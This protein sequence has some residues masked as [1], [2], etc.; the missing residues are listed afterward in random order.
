M[1][2]RN[3]P[4]P[5]VP[6]PGPSDGRQKFFE[7]LRKGLIGLGAL[8]F[9]GFLF[10]F[11]NWFFEYQ[12]GEAE[13]KAFSKANFFLVF[14]L[15]LAMAATFGLLVFFDVTTPGPLE[16]KIWALDLKGPAGP[17]I[18]WV[19]VSLSVVLAI[20]TL[21]SKEPEGVQKQSAQP[22]H[23]ALTLQLHAQ[24]GVAWPIQVSFHQAT[25]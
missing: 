17:I 12:M 25:Y 24:P 7:Q 8:I 6:L 15:P 11:G 4:P 21:R 1:V 3:P 14:G 16:V 2:S 23:S 19:I 10:Y 20:A 22:H 5:P 18:L 13:W 9:L